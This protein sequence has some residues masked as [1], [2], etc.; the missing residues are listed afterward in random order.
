[1]KFQIISCNIILNL[2]Q[3]LIGEITNLFVYAIPYPLPVYKSNVKWSIVPK[4]AQYSIM[5]S[6]PD[7]AKASEWSAAKP[8]IIGHMNK[9]HAESLKAYL[10]FYAHL[11]GRKFY[12]SSRYI[13]SKRN[14]VCICRTQKGAK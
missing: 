11:K 9:D 12:I 6:D 7:S 13:L 14:D 2:S 3:F 5:S 1:M 8:R 10:H 4:G